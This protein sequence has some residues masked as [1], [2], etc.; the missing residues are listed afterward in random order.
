MKRLTEEPE[1][2]SVLLTILFVAATYA[3]IL[4]KIVFL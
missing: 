3:Y 1:Y 2:V 4:V